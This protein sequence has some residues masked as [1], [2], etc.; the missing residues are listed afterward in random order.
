MTAH[1]IDIDRSNFETAVL[2]E[3]RKRP[4][5][6]DFWAPWC[7][8]CRALTPVLERLAEA[9]AGR[10]LLARVNSDENAELAAAFGVRGIPNV[11][12]FDDG[13]LADEFTGA[14]P[15]GAVR[16]FIDRLLPSAAELKRREAKGAFARGDAAAALAILEAA[17]AMEPNDDAIKLDRAEIL[18]AL[19][20]AT[21]AQA[22]LGELGPLALRDPRAGRL[23]A[24]LAFAQAPDDVSLADLEQRVRTRPADLDARL[25]LA[26]RYAAERRYEPAL[27]QLLQI[28]RADRR[29]ADDA[30]RKNMLAV[31][32]LLGDE[33]ELTGK[34]RRLLAAALH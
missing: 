7:G 11:K 14:L 2:E 4:V 23:R 30:G 10:F 18:H 31:F 13:K 32:E 17:Q 3:S 6:V 26:R 1:A 8:P 33:H 28:V 5:L 34:Y 20:R 27:E 19:G 24:E 25:A 9:Y 15:E 16:Q 22:L 29:F 21:E 12:A